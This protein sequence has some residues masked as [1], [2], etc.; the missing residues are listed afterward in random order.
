MTLGFFILS[1]LDLLSAGP[2]TFPTTQQAEIRT[3]ILKCQHPHGGFCGSTNHIYPE[4]Y[5]GKKEEMDP[6]NL[7]ATFFALLSLG[8]VGGLEG[9]KRKECLSWLKRLQRQD[10][11]FGEWIAPD[12]KIQG[13]NDMRYCYVASAIRWVLRGGV[14][15][16]EQAEDDINLEGLV[17]HLRNGQVWEY[18]LKEVQMLMEADL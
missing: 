11:S 18:S 6:A 9:V 12:G 3:W 14:P 5:Y 13:G 2:D 1:A 7:P 4:S 16:G 8:F 15:A 10:G 17:G